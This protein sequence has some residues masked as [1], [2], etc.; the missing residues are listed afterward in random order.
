MKCKLIWCNVRKQVST[1]VKLYESLDYD[2]IDDFTVQNSKGFTI[3][4]ISMGK[5]VY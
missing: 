1:N 2:I 5:N 3:D 4:V